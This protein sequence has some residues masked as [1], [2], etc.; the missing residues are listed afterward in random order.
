MKNDRKKFAAD[1][2]SAPEFPVRQLTAAQIKNGIVVRVPNWLGDAIMAVPALMQ[3]KKIIPQP[4]ALFVICPPVLEQIFS[5]MKFIDRVIPLT[6]AHRNWT[7]EDRSTVKAL[8]AGAGIFFNNSPRDVIALRR[9]GIRNLYGT[10]DRMRWLLLSRSFKFPKRRN[11][12]LNQLHHTS[13][14]LSMVK[15]LGAPEW[16]GTLPDLELSQQLNKLSDKIRNICAQPKLM[17][18]AAGAAYGSSKRW[19]TE[20]FHA[21]AEQWIADGGFVATLGT[22]VEQEN[23]AKIISG[24]PD[25]SAVNLCGETSMTELIYLLK[26]STVCVANDSGVMHLSA[27]LDRPGI[28][29][30]GPTDPSSTSPISP[31]WQVMFD[32]QSC[33]PCF[34]RECP[35]GTAI[36]MQVITPKMVIEK[37]P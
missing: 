24:L 26:N 35:L 14:Y 27:L 9:C 1:L 36:C 5:A 10:T 31:N 29:I 4:A 18:L 15:A 34:K 21:V 12:I 28:A 13:K 16:D 17:T 2:P 23:G 20:N 25:S 6:A 3:L 33:A 19:S 22:E 8:N 30:F 32:K 7:A 37:L 11:L